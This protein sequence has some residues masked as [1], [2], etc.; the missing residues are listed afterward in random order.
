MP[1]VPD[2]LHPDRDDAWKQHMPEY[3]DM[4]PVCKERAQR[5]RN[6]TSLHSSLVQFGYST[7]TRQEVADAYDGALKGEDPAGDIIRMMVTRQ[8]RDAGLIAQEND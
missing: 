7:L 2:T 1:K 6:I 4:C 5:G 3:A 8:M